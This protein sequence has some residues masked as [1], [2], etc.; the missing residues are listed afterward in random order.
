MILYSIPND[1]V[2]GIF[3]SKIV[4]QKPT[5]ANLAKKKKNFGEWGFT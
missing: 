4:W 2:P 5:I 1:T 3:G